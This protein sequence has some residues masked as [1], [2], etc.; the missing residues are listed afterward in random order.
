[1]RIFRTIGY[2]LSFTVLMVF[3]SGLS[4]AKGATQEKLSLEQYLEMVKKSDPSYKS[5]ELMRDGAQKTEAGAS[6]MTG[7]NLFSTVSSLND[8]RPT[9]NTAAQGDKTV[10]NG[11]AVGLKQQ[12]SLGI[13]WS[14][15]Q[16]YTYTKI[17][18]ASLIP[19]PEYYDAFPK[20]E[21][22]IPLW[23]NLL[24]AETKATQ[25]QL[26]SQLKLQKVSAEMA[27]IQKESE[28]KEAYFNLATQQENYEIQKDSLARAEKILSWAQSRVSRNLS[29]KSDLYQTQA[30]T[31]SRRIEL[32]NA[33]N[34]L[35]EAARL[36]N[37]YLGSSSE[38]VSSQLS[39]DEIDL[40]ALRLKKA[41]QKT[42]MDLLLQKEN[43]IAQERNYLSQKEKNKPS[44]D[45]SLVYSKQ[46]RDTTQTGAQSNTFKDN[47][48]YVLAA[49]NY[50][51]PLDIGTNSDSKEGF[52]QLAQSQVL[53][54]KVRQ[55]NESLEWSK[56]VDQAEMLSQQLR[57]VRELEGIQK[58][59]ADLERTKYNNGRSTTYQALTF[60]QDYINSRI[61]RINLELQ[62]RKFINSLE[63]YK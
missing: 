7:L 9:T 61:Q 59:K 44:L 3:G 54:E 33:D 53:A 41:E 57:I 26:E 19:V 43:I 10:A 8:G 17:S 51:M 23:R 16:N 31:S 28:I 2:Q 24:G 25:T 48:D 56:A 14:L 11:F 15:S 50:T 34:K 20:I 35:K 42:R 1:M 27:L 18:N 12:S 32:M 49:L 13:Q 29:D 38:V 55:R 40:K 4:F 60:E 58:N 39:A 63:L 47:K 22:N 62:L 37:S 21:M 30:L 46:G 45:L 52:A 5:S 6:L 36:F